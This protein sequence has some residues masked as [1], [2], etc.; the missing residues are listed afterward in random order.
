MTALGDAVAEPTGEND[1]L[2]RTVEIALQELQAK[3]GRAWDRESTALEVVLYGEYKSGNSGRILALKEENADNPIL[4]LHL[5]DRLAFVL[6]HV[7]GYK[8]KNAAEMRNV[9]EKQFRAHLHHA[10]GQ[11]ASVRDGRQVFPGTGEPGQ[12]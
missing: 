3:P 2:V 10:Y 8:I 12:A 6:H 9:D 5:T 1:L 4:S 7:L 11:L